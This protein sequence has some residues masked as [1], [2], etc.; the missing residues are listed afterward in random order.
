[1]AI[2]GALMLAAQILDVRKKMKKIEGPFLG[3]HL[4]GARKMN[5]K[6]YVR[7]RDLLTNSKKM[8]IETERLRMLVG[9]S[10]SIIKHDYLAEYLATKGVKQEIENNN[11]VTTR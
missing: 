6:Q 9:R 1:M 8:K 5:Q 2:V 4:G 3:P 11:Y 10:M 7:D